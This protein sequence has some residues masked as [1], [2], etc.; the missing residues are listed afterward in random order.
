V[1]WAISGLEAGVVLFALGLTLLYLN[2]FWHFDESGFLDWRV[3]WWNAASTF[4]TA[5]GLWIVALALIG[6]VAVIVSRFSGRQAWPYGIA[7]LLVVCTLVWVAPEIWTRILNGMQPMVSLLFTCK[8]GTKRQE[9]GIQREVPRCNQS[10]KS[11]FSLCCATIS[12][13]TIGGR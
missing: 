3:H 10:F 7:A 6:S 8:P 9:P 4:L 2:P 1:S 11:R 12:N 13:S 5:A